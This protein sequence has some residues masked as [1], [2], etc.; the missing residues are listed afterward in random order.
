M[1][2]IA[3]ARRERPP[4]PNELA[5]GNYFVAA[6]PPFSCWMPSQIH[7][8]EEAL[9]KPAANE[10]FGIYVHIPFC[11]KKCDYCYYLSHVGAGYEAVN[12]Y[13]HYLE[14][15]TGHLLPEALVPFSPLADAP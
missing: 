9:L 5:V 12:H 4:A 10:P 2:A 6:Y 3:P 14:T 7:A 1:I 15:L 11:Q 8:V 13:N